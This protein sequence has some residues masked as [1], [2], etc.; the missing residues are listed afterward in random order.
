MPRAPAVVWPVVWKVAVPAPLR[1]SFDYLPPASGAVILPGMRVRVP[2]GKRHSIGVV[3]EAAPA[4][5]LPLERLKP[6]T[7]T[8]DASPLLP[9]ALLALL[10]E[11][12]AYY[13]HPIGDVVAT[14]LPAPLRAGR[15]AEIARESVWRLVPKEGVGTD[16]AKAPKRSARRAALLELLAAHPDGIALRAIG[17]RISKPGALLRTLAS[18]GVVACAPA[19]DTAR[20]R[21]SPCTRPPTLSG[22]Q[23]AAADALRAALGQ[24]ACC[25]LHGVT[26]SGK[27]E[28]YLHAIGAAV[29][30]TGQALVL[31]P[32]I[33]LAPQ[34]VARIEARLGVPAAVMHS[35]RT[36]RERAD[37]WLRARSGEARVIVGTRSAVFAPFHDLRLI[38][39]DEEHDASYKQ[40][41]GFRYSARDLAVLRGARS[42]V[43]VVLGSATPSLETL[44][45]VDSGRYRLLTLPARAGSAVL[46]QVTLLDARRLAARD[47]LVAPLVDAI[48]ARLDRGEQS[49]VFINRRGFAPVWMCHACGWVENCARCDA[50]MTLH[51]AANLLRCHHCAAERAPETRCPTCASDAVKALGAGTQRIEAVLRKYFPEARIARID[52]DAVARKGAFETQL[53]DIAA[54]RADILVGT[55]ML[56]KG[57]DFPNLT[58][59]GVLD[60]DQGLYSADFRAAE[61]SAAMLHQVAGRSGR[62]DKPGEVLI[63]TQHPG[64]A[65]FASLKAHDYMAFARML[66]AD[67]KRAGFPPHAFFAL[68][69]AEAPRREAAH[70]FLVAARHAAQGLVPAQ[71][72][73][74][75]PVP[76][77]MERRAGRYRAQLLVRAAARRALHDFL[78]RWIEAIEAL[79]AARRAR[80]SL[81]VD[82]L[83]LN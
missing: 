21:L 65:L 10:R 40:Q 1:R 57:H 74:Y 68:L 23:L 49:L 77:P 64:H 8:L 25:V 61:Q 16:A 22:S 7:A 79:P 48:R 17:A 50:R 75:E 59:V 70:D 71:V 83:D 60:A 2:W 47:G 14:A 5:D 55:Q 66:L 54:G 45:N 73:V 4:S 33:G 81:D 30:G 39:V 11:A 82:P 58:L 12:A 9:P 37:A 36:D 28:V 62:A 35:S 6:I 69:R 78:D 56:A 15:G 72:R 31:V 46:P 20:L 19:P 53:A 13:H 38:V 41:D 76:A 18:Q 29:A 34:I 32:E 80:W 67:R 43:P 63:P 24:F 27:T 51:R 42:G 52:R 3:I 26:G 44:A